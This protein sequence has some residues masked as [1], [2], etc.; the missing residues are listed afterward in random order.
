MG[1]HSKRR[2]VGLQKPVIVAAT[3]AV[4]LAAGGTGT[5]LAS[6]TTTSGTTVS[7]SGATQGGLPS[8]HD[9]G[10]ESSYIIYKGQRYND[11]NEAVEGGVPTIPAWVECLAP[12]KIGKFA[13]GRFITIYDDLADVN[14]KGEG[15]R[16]VLR[17]NIIGE[18][19]RS[20]CV[21]AAASLNHH[22]KPSSTT[23]DRG[24]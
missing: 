4:A 19:P 23:A 9:Q 12:G 21:D 13:L 5:A 15:F 14:N 11:S 1:R 17:G 7:S 6:T 20:A 8:S 2:P 16:Q 18:I 3:T 22:E 10:N 24:E